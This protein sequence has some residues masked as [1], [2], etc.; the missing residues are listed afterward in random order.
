EYT[1]EGATM[2]LLFKQKTA[3]EIPAIV[4][5]PFEQT[6]GGVPGLKKH[7][8]GAAT[9]TMAG[10]AEQCQR[11]LVLRRAAFPPQ[12]HPERDP[13]RPIRPYQQHQGEAIHGLLLLTGEHP[14]Q[15]LDG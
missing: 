11:E 8:L 3:Y 12:P 14:C 9:Q 2:L 7:R 4:S 6:F 5:N 10:R 1:R 15:T 13:E